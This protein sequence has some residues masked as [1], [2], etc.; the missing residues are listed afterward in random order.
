MK[1]IL[2]IAA[3]VLSLSL[4]MQAQTSIGAGLHHAHSNIANVNGVYAELGKAFVNR[5]DVGFSPAIRLNYDWRKGDLFSYDLCQISVP[6]LF[7][8]G[9]ELSNAARAFVYAGPTPVFGL[10]FNEKTKGVS[11]SSSFSLYQKYRR[12]DIM[13]GAGVGIDLIDLFRIRIGYDFGLIN[14]YKEGVVGNQSTHNR[15]F[16]AGISLI[17]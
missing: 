17:L 6:I 5:F 11:G 3:A 9:V 13:L 8:Y 14:S 1:K 4:P 7:D 10:F 12:A 2:V 15:A 16:T